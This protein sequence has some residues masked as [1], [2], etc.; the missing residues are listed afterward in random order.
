MTIHEEFVRHMGKTS[1]KTKMEIL[2]TM[3]QFIESEDPIVFNKS[4]MINS[5]WKLDP[6]TVDEFMEIVY[7]CQNFFPRIRIS[8]KN[9]KKVFQHLDY[10]ELK[11]E[12]QTL[13]L[14]SIEGVD[15]P[16]DVLT[17]KVFPVFKCRECG[18]EL[19]YPSHHNEPMR[20]VKSSGK[21]IC[22]LREC[23][24]TQLIPEHHRKKMDIFVK[25]T[26]RNIEKGNQE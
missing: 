12:M 18:E 17:P 1:R 13:T 9:G 7:F 26:N 14:E 19:G 15:T 23:N 10:Q 5:P 4:S 3:K 24:F 6:R 11:R 20:H 8:I 25:Y 22:A 16:F 21:L 2:E